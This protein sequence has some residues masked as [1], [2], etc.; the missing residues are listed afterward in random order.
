MFK[1]LF[2]LCTLLPCFPLLSIQLLL[3]TLIIELMWPDVL[4]GIL[5]CDR[6]EEHFLGI[7]TN[8]GRDM[9]NSLC[10]VFS[11]L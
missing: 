11:L 6:R 9:K 4:C 2:L 5:R 8:I 10:A 1:S 3:T 7:S